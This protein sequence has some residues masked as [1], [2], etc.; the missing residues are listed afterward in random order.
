LTGSDCNYA[1]NYSITNQLSPPVDVASEVAKHADVEI[2]DLPGNADGVVLRKPGKKPLV[3]LAARLNVNRKRFTLAHELGH[4]VLPWQVGSAFCHPRQTIVAG[5][6]LHTQIER[7]ANQFATELLV[8]ETW[9]D[10][11]IG[12][13]SGMLATVV[14]EIGRM[15]GVSPITAAIALERTARVR[16]AV[17]ITQQDVSTKYTSATVGCPL[18]KHS[19]WWNDRQ[20]VE[21]AGGTVST[22]TFGKYTLIAAEFSD[23]AQS[24][25]AQPDEESCAILREILSELPEPD[26]TTLMR[27]TNGVIGAGNPKAGDVCVV[28]ELLR[29]RFVDRDALRYVT[30]HARFEDFLTAKAY[31]LSER[32]KNG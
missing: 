14:M 9:M 21:Q 25:V 7:E 22:E 30:T 10:E 23:Q 29:A 1:R 24:M 31:E 17:A 11:V 6:M 26:R 28:L 32:W 20:M 15:A 18:P 5:E 13:R 27:S 8:P 12:A 16:A 3:L 4:L 2:D 19:R